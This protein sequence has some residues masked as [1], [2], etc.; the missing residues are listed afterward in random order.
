M[1]PWEAV[2]EVVRAALFLV[3]HL[4][5]GSLGWGIVTLSVLVR[6]A[7]LP[8]TL[9][10]ARRSAAMREKMKALAPQLERVKQRHAKDP[11]A[12]QAALAREYERAGIRPLRDSGLGVL[13]AQAPVGFALYKV[14]R[15]GVGGGTAFLWIANLSRPDMLLAVVTSALTAL[16]SMTAPAAASSRGA[17][18]I[19]L[20]SSAVTFIIVM[21]LASGVALYWASST[22]VGILQNVLIRRRPLNAT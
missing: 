19:A 7:L 4:C 8:W 5:G 9:K 20:V 18:P 17:L 22:G 12:L 21:Q 2:L 15:D 14:I 1:G 11:V 13:A 10:A 16:V 3:S 6:L